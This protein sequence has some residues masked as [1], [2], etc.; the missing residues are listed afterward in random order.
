M[1]SVPAID[2]GWLATI[3][4]GRPPIVAKAGDEVRRPV[5]AQL[6]QVAVVDDA[7]RD[8][9]HVVGTGG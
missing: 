4:T 1:S 6:E 8:V 5:G 7:G 2:I 9:P 3:P